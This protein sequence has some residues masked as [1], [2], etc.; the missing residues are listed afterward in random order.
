MPP[1]IVPKAN[2]DLKATIKTME[3]VLI[4]SENQ[5]VVS[6]YLSSFFLKY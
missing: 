2:Q 1:S 3:K 6:N 4:K 5:Y